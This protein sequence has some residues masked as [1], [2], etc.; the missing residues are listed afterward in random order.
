MLGR[1]AFGCVYQVHKLEY[2]VIAAKVINEENFNI[3]EWKIGFQLAQGV[4]NPFVL[5]YYSAQMF[6]IH[7]ILLMEYANM[8]SLDNLIESKQ[9]LPLSIIRPIM[10]QLFEGL[11]LMHEKGLIHR[12]I[13]GQNILLHNPLGTGLVQLK[14]A[15]FGLVKVQQQAVQTMTTTVAG[16]FPFMAPEALLEKYQS[17]DNADYKVDI[18]SAGI[19]LFQLTAHQFPFKD[20]SL[21]EILT[22]MTNKKLQ[23]PKSITDNDL[24]NLITLL[25]AF[26]PKDRLSATE[27]LNHKFFT[28]KHALKEITK[29]VKDL[30]LIYQQAQQQGVQNVTPYDTNTLFI[31]PLTEV[32]RILLVAQNLQ[33]GDEFRNCCIYAGIANSLQTIFEK[34]DLKYITKPFIVAFFQLTSQYNQIINYTLLT[35]SNLLISGLNT[36][37]STSYHPHFQIISACDGIN[38]L[39]SIFM[40][41]DDKEIKDCSAICIGRL[42]RAQQIGDQSI[43]IAIISHLKSIIND[44]DVWTREASRDTLSE[45]S[46]NISDMRLIVRQ[47]R[48]QLVGSEIEQKKIIQ[49]QEN[50]CEVLSIILRKRNEDELFKIVINSGIVEALLAILKDRE[51]SLITSL[52]VSTYFQLTKSTD[53]TVVF[54][55]SKKNPYPSLIRLLNHN[56][57]YVLDY[58]VKSINNILIAGANT[59]PFS[60]PH[61]HFEVLQKNGDIDIL[62]SFFKSNNNKKTKDS[63]AICIGEIFRNQEIKDQQVKRAII[64]H[65]KLLLKDPDEWTRGAA[66]SALGSLVQNQGNTNEILNDDYLPSIQNDLKIKLEGSEQHKLE[67][68]SLQ[69]KQTRALSEMLK[70]NQTDEFRRKVINAGIYDSLLLIILNREIELITEPYLDALF[71]LTISSDKIQQILLKKNPYP[72]LIRLFNHNDINVIQCAIKSIFNLLICGLN[73]TLSSTQHPHFEVMSTCGGINK[74][75]SLF[76]KTKDKDTKDR[77]AICVGRLYRAKEDNNELKKGIIPHIKS[78]INDQNQY[79]SEQSRDSLSE[80]FYNLSDMRLIARQF[81][82]QLSGSEE[83]IETIVEKQEIECEVLSIILQKR[84]G[85]QIREIIINSG[86]VEALLAI[87]KDRDFKLITTYFIQVIYQL[88]LS[89]ND[90]KLLLYSKK[91]PYPSLIRLLTHT[92]NDFIQTILITIYNLLIAGSNKMPISSPHPHFEA[93]DEDRGIEK[94]YSIFKRTDLDKEFKDNVAIIIAQVFKAKEIPNNKLMR[95]KI[96]SH[97]KT[98]IDDPDDWT[99]QTS[100]I[101]LENLDQNSVNHEEIE[102]DGFK[103]SELA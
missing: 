46:Q 25:L 37:P 15:D 94:L 8:K 87:L 27:A 68:L 24:W 83:Q 9:D 90:L 75:I 47:L 2:G 62:F 97:L 72:S 77:V 22:F 53:K 55:Y 95:T 34:R 84:K 3:N 73:T 33:K 38:K 14:I 61:P 18:W 39:F 98:L 100:R 54:L 23:R 17:N 64:S 65:L 85:D 80:L 103:L 59:T 52:F 28:G 86:I 69:E 99:K 56:D 88:S 102:K 43:K 11:R 6:G 76:N 32:R 71:S 66:R 1:G 7:T 79:I 48:I 10:R 30:A 36:T 96:I 93:F 44:P 40:K 45:L 49:K 81:R 5:K 50:E 74:L 31:V 89:S 78:L 21:K 82:I 92:D 67:I 57:R 41:S 29:E 58:T 60:S 42:Y 51:L 19:L 13:K 70:N 63:A 12:D 20:P 91:N 26:D 101:K 4:Q 35:I 16:T